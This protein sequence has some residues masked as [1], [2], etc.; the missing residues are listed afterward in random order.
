MLKIIT[1]SDTYE[2]YHA[3][4]ALVS[5][6]VKDTDYDLLTVD[7]DQLRS[8]DDLQRIL[9]SNTLFSKGNVVFAKRVMNANL[10]K[11]ISANL[12]VFNNTYLVIW[13]DQSLDGRQKYVS[14]LK[15]SQVIESYDLPKYNSVSDMTP[16]VKE[17]AKKRKLKLSS[18]VIELLIQHSQLDKWLIESTLDKLVLFREVRKKEKEKEDEISEED[19]NTLCAD[20]DNGD[21]WKFLDATTSGKKYEALRELEKLMRF[22]ENGQF[23]LSMLSRELGLLAKVRYADD[24]HMDTEGLKL[25]PFV[26]KKTRAKASKFSWSVITRLSQ[27]LVRLDLAIKEGRLDDMTGITLFVLSFPGR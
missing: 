9:S 14:E 3:A 22:S 21:V 20:T 7:G 23:L 13:E 18:H 19:F 2:S 27:A 1:G 11:Y 4:K 5:K 15:K 17:Q 12:E 6:L 10:G 8:G 16:W 25:H 24:N 26:L